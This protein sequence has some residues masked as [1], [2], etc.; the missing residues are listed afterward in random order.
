MFMGQLYF[1]SEGDFN[2]ECTSELMSEA[3]LKTIADMSSKVKNT[4]DGP[5]ILYGEYSVIIDQ[6]KFEQI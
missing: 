1:F 4:Y 5:E 3:Q 6:Y 2:M